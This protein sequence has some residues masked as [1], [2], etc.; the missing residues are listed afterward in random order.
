MKYIYIT[1]IALFSTV[2]SSQVIN[3]KDWTGDDTVNA[4]YKDVDNELN[5]FIGTYQLISNSGN[6]EMTI[7]FK[8]FTNCYNTEFYQDVLA[9]EI[10]FKKDGVLYFDNL[11]KINENYS[12][13][14]LHDICGNT[15][16]ANQTRPTCD[17]CLPNQFRA[18]L[19]YFGRSDNCGGY[20]ILQKFI[21]G[22]QEKMKVSFFF[23]CMSVTDNVVSYI[24]GGDYILIK[25]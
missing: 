19:I 3:L 18:N 23:N 12:N 7:V 22:G 9:G 8:K 16:M 1:I 25:Q 11:N 21:E 5:Q 24:P 6:D 14:Y 4:Y 17:N 2:C 20:V 13:K 10:K 15:L